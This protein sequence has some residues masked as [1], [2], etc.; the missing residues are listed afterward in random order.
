M[1][2][3]YTCE[4]ERFSIEYA[5]QMTTLKKIMKD[6]QKELKCYPKGI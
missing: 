1:K 3:F 4:H 2:I 5:A 6:D